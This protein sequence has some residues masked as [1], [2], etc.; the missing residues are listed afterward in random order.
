MKWVLWINRVLLTVLS[1]ATGAVKIAQMEAEMVIFRA[2]GFPDAAT[3]AF[4]VVQIAGGLLLLANK[5]T[6][7][8]AW[9]MLVT[10]AFATAVLFVNNMVVFGVASLLFI[11]MAA[12]HAKK[13]GSLE[14]AP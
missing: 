5:T 2:I 6:R 10:F 7:I 1:I 14:A 13:W 9:V 3:I 11:A 4:G 8:G 12:L